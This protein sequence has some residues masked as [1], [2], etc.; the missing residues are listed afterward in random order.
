M[1]ANRSSGAILP[2]RIRTV[3]ETRG[4]NLTAKDT[5]KAHAENAILPMPALGHLTPMKKKPDS[6]HASRECSQGPAT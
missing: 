5:K 2:L 3:S 1:H 6:R 4:Y